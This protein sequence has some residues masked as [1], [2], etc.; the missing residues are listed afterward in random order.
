MEKSIDQMRVALKN[1]ERKDTSESLERRTITSQSRKMKQKLKRIVSDKKV[2]EADFSNDKLSDR[3]MRKKTEKSNS[4]FDC[5]I[6]NLCSINKL[7]KANLLVPSLKKPSSKSSKGKRASNQ[8]IGQLSYQGNSIKK[9]LRDLNSFNA[10]K[11]VNTSAQGGLSGPF[12]ALSPKRGRP[13]YAGCLIEKILSSK[14]RKQSPKPALPDR[15]ARLKK[16]ASSSGYLRS[17]GRRSS[18]S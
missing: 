3:T 14:K 4:I 2:F 10:E 8:L 15:R 6:A 12:Q 9:M 13:T 18:K 17:A 7:S 1:N 16:L 11:Q 5:E